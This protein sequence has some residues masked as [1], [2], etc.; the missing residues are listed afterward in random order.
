MDFATTGV[1]WGCKGGTTALSLTEEPFVSEQI[2]SYFTAFKNLAMSRTASGV[3]TLR[4]H[5]D[6]GPAT[7]TGEMHTDFPRALF[8]IGEDRWIETLP[9]ELYLTH[10]FAGPSELV[11]VTALR[12][13]AAT[14]A[15]RADEV[16][17]TL[18]N[19]RC[20][21]VIHY[22]ANCAINR[23]NITFTG[24]KGV[25][26]VDILSDA[27]TLNTL[28]D[29]TIRR[30]LGLE[31]LNSLQRLTHAIASSFDATSHSQ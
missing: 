18:K 16:T 31:Y 11:S 27:L 1:V 13:P 26:F 10:Y 2:P 9:H 23:R 24:T 3:L 25:I 17:L 14:S 20:I 4:F 19:D 21:T 6:D 28:T 15:V 7:F 8:E 30:G 22:S 5:T 12:T 29:G